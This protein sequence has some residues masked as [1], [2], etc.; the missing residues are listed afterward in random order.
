MT[1]CS[2]AANPSLDAGPGK[3]APPR[4]G[5]LPDVDAPQ[6]DAAPDGSS[7]YSHTVVLD[8]SDDFLAAETFGTTSTAYTARVTWDDQNL[9]I[10]YSG[11]DLNPTALD[12]ASKWL[13]VYIDTDP[14]AGTGA[15]K[16]L[17]YNTQQAVFPS[18]FGAELYARWKCT[19]TF[20]SIEQFQGGTTYTTVGTPQ[21]G[22]AGTFV[23]FAIPRSHFNG[24]TTIG[25]VTWM[26]NEKPNFEGSFAGLFLGNFG[27][28][29]STALPITKYLRLDLTAA[30]VPND[31]SNAVAP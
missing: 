28:G 2:T 3:D 29:Y 15:I 4:D 19:A 17:K 1:A 22:H 23:E 10:G 13:F 6:T 16:S 18:G 20:S 8:G 25:L 27:D 14:G 5:N 11:P 12:T 24:S 9:Y 30:T 26:I 21:S 7:A 31:P